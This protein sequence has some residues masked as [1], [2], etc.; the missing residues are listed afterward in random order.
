[1]KC[2]EHMH[3][4]TVQVVKASA[5]LD[6]MGAMAAL[7]AKV[8]EDQDYFRFSLERM[9]VWIIYLI[10]T[11]RRQVI[12][13]HALVHQDVRQLAKI[14]AK[15]VVDVKDVLEHVVEGVQESL[16]KV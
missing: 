5:L 10:V 1:M 15:V 3:Y 4:V 12:H 6:V 8:V 2:Q 9:V 13:L 14:N 16:F 11:E 7:G